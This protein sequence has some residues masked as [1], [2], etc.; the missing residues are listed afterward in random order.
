MRIPLPGRVAA[1]FLT[2]WCAGVFPVHA[3]PLSPIDQ[4]LWSF[5]G[6][7][8]S[9]GSGRLAGVAL[10]SR[11]LGDEPFDNP[12]LRSKTSGQVTGLLHRANRQDLRTDARQFDETSFFVDAS[13]AWGAYPIAGGTL[14]GY[15]H[16]P[17]LRKE[18]NAFLRGDPGNL[19]QAAVIQSSGTSR[20]M[21]A[22]AGWSMGAG[23]W[24][25]AGAVEWTRREDV[26]EYTEE[27]GSP[28]M[29]FRHIDFSGSGFGAQAGFAWGEDRSEAGAWKAGAQGRWIPAITLEGEQHFELLSGDSVGVV[30]GERESIVEGGLSMSWRPTAALR[31]FAGGGGRTGAD[32]SG[33]GVRSGPGASVSIGLDFHDVRD[34]WTLR[35][36]L[37]LEREDD[38]PEDRAGSVGL[39]LGWSFDGVMLDIGILHRSIDGGSKPNSYEDRLAITVSGGL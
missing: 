17:V 33:L 34:P 27:S 37:G 39:G 10:A 9:P 28:D 23:L 14:I 24:R 18:E 21:R 22:G 36:G 20:E 16:Q 5:P 13:G 7:F 35:F 31:L 3:Q 6:A 25:F 12:A 19:A 4:G 32:W 30:S 1:A 38:V 11:W 29:G 15:V 8:A 2:C 26:F